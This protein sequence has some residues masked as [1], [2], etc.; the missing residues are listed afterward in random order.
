[1]DQYDFYITSVRHFII[2][3]W[4]QTQNF[5]CNKRITI[6]N[7]QYSQYSAVI[8]SAVSTKKFSLWLPIISVLL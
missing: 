4:T 7:L 2:H 5:V 6:H 3:F 1:M 8:T